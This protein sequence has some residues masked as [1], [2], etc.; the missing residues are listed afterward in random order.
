M[1]LLRKRRQ[2][3]AVRQPGWPCSLIPHRHRL[4]WSGQMTPGLSSV[5]AVATYELR[6]TGVS[7][8]EQERPAAI[9]DAVLPRRRVADPEIG[10]SHRSERRVIRPD[11]LHPAKRDKV[12]HAGI[13]QADDGEP[14]EHEHGRQDRESQRGKR[15][16]RGTGNPSA[17][18]P[19]GQRGQVDADPAAAFADGRAGSGLQHEVLGAQR[20]YEL[21]RWFLVSHRSCPPT[22][23]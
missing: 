12:G 9:A 11:Q 15:P 6:T 22:G 10:R 17:T 20:V 19:A 23:S 7:H 13:D 3:R 1:L 5:M 14:A 8:G 16:R 4:F 18:S 21:R 2:V